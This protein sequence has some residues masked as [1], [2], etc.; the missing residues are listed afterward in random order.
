MNWI[1]FW[2][3]LYS[4][5]LLL[6]GIRQARSNDFE[7]YLVN[8]RKTGTWLL[9]ATTLATFVG[10]G[11]SMGL[12]TM[13]YESGFAAVGIGIAYVIGFFIVARFAGKIHQIGV[14]KNIYSFPQFLNKSYLTH[15]EKKF[16][17]FFS[18]IVTGVNITIFFA[19]LS[20]QFVGMASLLKFVLGMGY[21]T[22]AILSCLIV[23]GYTSVAGLSGVIITDLLQF[24][25]IVIMILTIF[26]PG[27]MV[28]T[29]NFSLLSTLPDNMLNGTF[30]GIG[31]LIGLQLFIAPSVLVRMDIWQRILAARSDKT[32][33]KMNIISGLGML[34][35]YIIFPLVGMAVRIK[36]GGNLHNEDATYVFLER[37]VT[38]FSMGFAVIGLL[39]VLMSSASSFLNV[40]AISAVRD[41]TGWRTSTAA[42]SIAVQKKQIILVSSLFGVIALALAL[43]F[44]EIVNLMVVGIGTIAIFVPITFLALISKQ[45]HPYRIWAAISIAAG[46]IINLGLFVLGIVNPELFEPKKSFIPAFIVS[47]LILATG[48]LI[49]KYRHRKK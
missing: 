47:G 18:L 2:M 34:P 41:F 20:A 23:V 39:S 35:F 4:L 7:K 14:K 25:I 37:H 40:V 19:L 43:A 13:G 9:V 48:V 42:S 28:D 44:P 36:T 21:Q 30:Y 6:I 16:S 12:I 38:D 10:G 27:V 49:E 22:S 8:N 32:A 45:V 31:F 15:S 24:V 5:C 46:F 17:R 3:V 29:E 1:I 11:T 26:V 33:R